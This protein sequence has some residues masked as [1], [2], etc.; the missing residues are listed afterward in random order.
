[1]RTT[2]TT[3]LFG[4]TRTIANKRYALLT[5]AGLVP[6][7]LPGWEKAVSQVFISPALGA[8]FSQLHITLERDGKCV[9]N[10]GANQYFVYVLDGTVN[11]LLEARK[12]RLETGGYA[13]VPS[14]Q[15]VQISSAA[16]GTRLLVY[17][18]KYQPLPGIAKPAGFAG[19]ERDI[20]T[21]PFR[22]DADLRVQGLLPN[23]PAF[24]MA[25][26]LLT[27]PPGGAPP[28]VEAPFMERGWM[29]LRG[30]AICHLD[31]DWHPVQA[32]DV[33]WAAAYCPQW[34]VAAGKGPATF[35]YYQDVNRDPM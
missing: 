26:N 29:L 18:K 35:I 21:Q 32:G 13:Y 17:Q 24:D 9:G 34:F 16:A 20:K 8:G 1:M 23:E 33:I 31:V 6:S 19:Q 28:V 27:C 2:E 4:L 22:G 30:H 15:D 14:E 11:I 12:H 25:V 7:H 3:G 5:P 10:T